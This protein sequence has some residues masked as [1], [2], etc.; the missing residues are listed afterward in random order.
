MQKKKIIYDVELTFKIR[1]DAFNK[2]V[3]FIRTVVDLTDASFK[4]AKFNES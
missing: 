1:T 4:I 3:S 2:N